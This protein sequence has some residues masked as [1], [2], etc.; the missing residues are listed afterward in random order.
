MTS[1]YQPV[2]FVPGIP[3]YQQ[4]RE[5]IQE[6][7]R[8]DRYRDIPL[9]D[10]TLANRFGVSRITVRKAVEGLVEAGLLHRIPKLGTFVRSGMF[11]EK[12]TLR[13]FLDPWS[14]KTGRLKVRIATFCRVKASREIAELLNV[15]TGAEVVYV[16]RLRFQESAL[17]IIDDR[18]LRVGDASHLTEK[19]IL[20]SSFVDYFQQRANVNIENG[21]MEIGARGARP[22]EAKAFGIRSG[23]PVLM[24][25]IILFGRRRRPVMAGL[26]VYRADRINYRLL[27]TKCD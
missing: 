10:A 25:R 15:R 27:V 12:L 1:Q 21:E 8:S 20:T 18:Y 3:L 11:Q 4:V 17:V 7:V 24:R 13:S 23:Q 22:N 5:Q 6:M 16:Q 14:E 9:T 19:D 26:S 2:R